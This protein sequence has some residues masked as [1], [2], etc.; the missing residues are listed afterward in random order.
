[1][2]DINIYDEYLC[3]QTGK[4]YFEAF[5]ANDGYTYERDY[6][7]NLFVGKTTIISPTT[8]EE[9]KVGG[10]SCAKLNMKLKEFYNKYPEMLE[11]QYVSNENIV[12]KF[13]TMMENK[14]SNIETIISY[15]EKHKENKKCKFEIFTYDNKFTDIFNHEKGLQYII[16]DT[17][18]YKF[19]TD[20]IFDGKS[21]IIIE[22][23]KIC[24]L[25]YDYIITH[26]PTA[27]LFYNACYHGRYDMIIKL[28]NYDNTYINH[29]HSKN[30]MNNVFNVAVM[31]ENLDILKFLHEKNP[32]LYKNKDSD[33]NTAFVYACTISMNLEIAQWLYS[34]DETQI[35][36]NYLK[37]EC[38]FDFACKNENIKMI[39]LLF[40]IDKNVVNKNPNKS[41]IIEE[42]KYRLKYC[43]CIRIMELIATNA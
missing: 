7:E 14:D 3:K 15:V 25:A 34:I 43:D 4:M 42:I 18:Y 17:I 29:I 21:N 8:G 33:G 28:Y 10:I 32:L 12:K 1:M 23:S 6:I 22:K 16:D 38:L 40:A 39:D 26:N 37:D 35:T 20:T 27:A 31:S 11:L 13:R 2:S 30:K 36:D 5:M 24:V 41:K 19:L 9:M